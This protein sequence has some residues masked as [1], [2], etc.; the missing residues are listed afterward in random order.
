MYCN[1]HLHGNGWLVHA[2][3]GFVRAHA[4]RATIARTLL[5]TD[6]SNKAFSVVRASCCRGEG[7]R[8]Y[9]KTVGGEA[10]ASP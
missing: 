1:R 8:L 6:G 2:D 4:L 3:D 9:T 7:N 5:L 10:G